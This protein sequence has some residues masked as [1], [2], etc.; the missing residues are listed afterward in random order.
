MTAWIW[1]RSHLQQA[2]LLVRILPIMINEAAINAVQHGREYVN[3]KDLFEAVEQVLVGKEK[4]DRIMSKEERRSFPIMRWATLLVSALPEK[5]GACSENHHRP[6]NHG[7]AW[8][9]DAGA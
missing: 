6:Q 9:R 5:L 4:K 3:Q 2:V 1:M 7:R 8:I